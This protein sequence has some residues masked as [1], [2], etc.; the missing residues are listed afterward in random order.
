M[1]RVEMNFA[2]LDDRAGLQG[3]NSW[4]RL[5]FLLAGIAAVFAGRLGLK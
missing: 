5:A 1:W 4:L 2:I 3:Y